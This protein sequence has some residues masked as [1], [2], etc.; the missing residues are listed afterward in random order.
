MFNK[1]RSFTFALQTFQVPPTVASLNSLGVFVCVRTVLSDDEEA[2]EGKEYDAD[3]EAVWFWVGKYA[4]LSLQEQ[5]AKALMCIMEYFCLPGDFP[6]DIIEEESIYGEHA[7]LWDDM[8][9]GALGG[10]C[11][12]ASWDGLF[13]DD[14]DPDNEDQMRFPRLYVTCMLEGHMTLEPLS[15]ICQSDLKPG[16]MAVLDTV[17]ATYVWRGSQAPAE[18]ASV[19]TRAAGLY[20]DGGVRVVEVVQGNEPAEFCAHFQSWDDNLLVTNTGGLG[21]RGGG[22]SSSGGFPDVYEQRIMRLGDEGKLGD[23]RQLR[24]RVMGDEEAKRYWQGMAYSQARRNQAVTAAG[25]ASVDVAERSRMRRGEGLKPPRGD[26]QPA[27]EGPVSFAVAKERFATGAAFKHKIAARLYEPSEV[28]EARL[29]SI[30]KGVVLLKDHPPAA[31]PQPP[32][33]PVVANTS[34][35]VPIESRGSST[36]FPKA[37][38]DALNAVASGEVALAAPLPGSRPSSLPRAYREQLY[39]VRVLIIHVTALSRSCSSLT[40]RYL[41]CVSGHDG[42]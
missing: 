13:P 38:Q 34:P 12:F 15:S 3:G 33:A 1:R 21:M 37:L 40:T 20:R 23:I 16:S 31:V 8:S 19:V 5:G 39:Q 35:A 14:F 4:S 18:F 25:L 17:E 32:A 9:E 22:N 27:S 6:V 29:E 42:Y 30:E 11:A 28:L 26:D 24:G 10:E 41:P 7:Q 36:A 2:E